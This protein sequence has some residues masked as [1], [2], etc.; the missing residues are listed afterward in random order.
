MKKPTVNTEFMVLKTRLNKPMKKVGMIGCGNISQAYFDAAKDLNDI[1]IVACADLNME[2][3][4]AKA[5]EN[6]CK[7]VT[8]D[9]ILADP[10]IEIILNLTTPQGHAPVNTAALLA[11]KHVHCEKPYAVTREEGKAV[12]ALSKEKGLMTGCAPDTFLGAGHQTARKM[13]DDGWIGKPIAGTAFMMCPGH[14]AWHPNPEFYYLKG[15]G[16]MFDMGP[17]YITALVNMLGPAKKV[18]AICGRALEE[19]TCTSESRSGDKMPVEVTTHLAG[20]I[21]FVNGAIITVIM[22]FDIK[23]N[24][25]PPIEIHGTAG[26]MRV[27]DPNGFGGSVQVFRPG[28]KEWKEVP[29]SHPYPGNMR[30]IGAADM[31]AAID[32]GRTNR[33]SGD[34]AYHVLDIMHAF[35]ESSETGTHVVLESTCERPAALPMAVDAGELS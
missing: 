24:S 13:I 9:E 21:E 32:D 2:V 27:P 18:A 34:V 8:V 12:L 11:G 28:N 19:R 14:E 31:A 23:K 1:E 26:S 10:E 17:Y 15:G 33:C 7:A 25:L 4:Q 6:G 29:H 22:S 5:E 20:T 35:D 30:S 16:P 3:A